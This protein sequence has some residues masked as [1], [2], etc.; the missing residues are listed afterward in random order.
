MLA[1]A[2]T[3]RPLGLGQLLDRSIRLYLRH[4]LPFTGIVAL[5][6]VPITLL[7]WIATLINLPN[8][9]AAAEALQNPSS[10]DPSAFFDSFNALTGGFITIITAFL[11]IVL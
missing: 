11:Q 6:L 7:Q 9:M 5:M 2:Q 10:N 3:L 4:F 1:E 8:A